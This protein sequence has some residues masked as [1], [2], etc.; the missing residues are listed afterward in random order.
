M[1]VLISCAFQGFKQSGT[2]LGPD[3]LMGV[4]GLCVVARTPMY[5]N[6]VAVVRWTALPF[7]LLEPYVLDFSSTSTVK[8]VK[9]TTSTTTSTSS[10]ISITFTASKII[11][12]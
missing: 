9:S 3:A 8:P 4:D 5:S 7:N 10:P 11:F 6:L 1:T 2:A 12:F